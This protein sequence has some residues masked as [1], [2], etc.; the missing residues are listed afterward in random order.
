MK[1][2]RSGGAR[3]SDG[4]RPLLRWS[5][6]LRSAR[7]RALGARGTTCVEDLRTLPTHCDMRKYH[8]T[9]SRW[10]ETPAVG[11][12]SPRRT[13]PVVVE[14]PLVPGASPIGGPSSPSTPQC[15][16]R[17]SATPRAQISVIVRAQRSISAARNHRRGAPRASGGRCRSATPHDLRHLRSGPDPA[18]DRPGGPP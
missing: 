17:P 6:A 12:E 14:R 18:E 4:G 3:H 11:A 7:R 9:S 1:P 10:V 8:R 16:R 2:R 13:P 5:R 15:V